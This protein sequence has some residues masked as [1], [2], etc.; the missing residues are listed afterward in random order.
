AVQLRLCV[1]AQFSA[2]Y[3]Y[4]ILLTALGDAEHRMTGIRA[5]ADDF[6][7]KPFNLADFEARLIAAERVTTVHRRRE[8]LLRQTQRFAAETD[9][10]RLMNDLLHEAMTLVGG[11]AGSVSRWDDDLDALVVVGATADALEP[12]RMR[13]GE[14][15][16]DRAAQQRSP[17]LV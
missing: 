9:P 8:A 1:R 11:S 12:A 13:L 14:G 3:T 15:A 10:V 6:I 16:S 5:G 7:A 4:F 17:V 2:P